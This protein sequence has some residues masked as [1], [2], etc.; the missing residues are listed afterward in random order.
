MESSD[1][2]RIQIKCSDGSTF[3]CDHLICTL[4]LGVLKKC[5]LSIFEPLLPQRKMNSI[6][7]MGFGTVNKIFVEYDQPFWD[8][9][10]E[11]IS[12]FW[13]P[14]QLKE[15]SKEDP[16]NAEWLKN[17]IGFYTVSFQPNILCGWISGDAARKMEMSN[18]VEFEAAVKRVFKIFLEPWKNT[19]IKNIIR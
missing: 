11:G 4:P 17:I 19:E 3:E 9:D 15:I 6:E 10:W 5:H 12:F 16:V 18:E 7:N 1:A 14:D 2:N 13:Q 8:K